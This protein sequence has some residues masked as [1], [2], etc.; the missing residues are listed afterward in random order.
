ML[1]MSEP[2]LNLLQRPLSL[3]NRVLGLLAPPARARDGESEVDGGGVA[4]DSVELLFDGAGYGDS[5]QGARGYGC[6]GEEAGREIETEV[7]S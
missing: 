3:R 2:P 4:R 1:C 6:G 5:D 7:L